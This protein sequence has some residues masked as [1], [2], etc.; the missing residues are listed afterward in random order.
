MS[1]SP[2]TQSKNLVKIKGKTFR[3]DALSIK[4]KELIYHIRNRF[5]F[6][7]IV[8]EVRDGEPY[9]MRRYVEFQSIG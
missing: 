3:L 4:E 6:G 7:E 5:K 1:E 2:K 9:R 8:I